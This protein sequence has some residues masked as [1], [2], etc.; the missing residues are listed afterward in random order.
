MAV[1]AHWVEG[2]KQGESWGNLKL[3]ASLI[4]F[5]SLPGRHTGEHLAECFMFICSRLDI[6]EKV[7]INYLSL[8]FNLKNMC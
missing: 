4:G 2:Q 8:Y 6:G 3:R 7:R 5:H 1:T